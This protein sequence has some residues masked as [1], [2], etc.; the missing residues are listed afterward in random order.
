MSEANEFHPC[1]TCVGRSSSPKWLALVFAITA[2]ARGDG[3]DTAAHVLL[4]YL[5]QGAAGA[6]AASAPARTPEQEGAAAGATP[7][8]EGG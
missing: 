8:D 7:L 2:A 1:V 5:L 6:A 4:P 3:A